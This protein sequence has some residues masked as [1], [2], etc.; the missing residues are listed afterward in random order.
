M[1]PKVFLRHNRTMKIVFIKQFFRIDLTRRLNNNDKDEFIWL[2]IINWKLIYFGVILCKQVPKA[3]VWLLPN[4][5]TLNFTVKVSNHKSNTFALKEDIYKH[6]HTHNAWVHHFFL[7]AFVYVV[8][9]KIEFFLISFVWLTI[10]RA[11]SKK[12]LCE[13]VSRLKYLMLI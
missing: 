2:Q 10:Q 11:K 4:W 6:K 5:H 7:T 3:I 8:H 1:C 12:P 9:Q 13:K